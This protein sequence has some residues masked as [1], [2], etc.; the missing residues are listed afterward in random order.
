MFVLS[1]PLNVQR[2]DVTRL[3]RGDRDRNSCC[4]SRRRSDFSP[5][6]ALAAAAVRPGRSDLTLV[7]ANRR[8]PESADRFVTDPKVD[9]DADI[10][11]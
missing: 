11:S 5:A 9:E 10:R 4:R 1:A 6:F 8:S 2:D 3:A 7:R